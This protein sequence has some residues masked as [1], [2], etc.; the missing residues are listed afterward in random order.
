M[1]SDPHVVER[2][3]I[4]TTLAVSMLTPGI[5]YVF[6]SLVQAE[7]SFV[8]SITQ[9]RILKKQTTVFKAIYYLL[10]CM[11]LYRILGEIIYIKTTTDTVLLYDVM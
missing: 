6:S 3:T 8:R 7:L 4:M 10:L 11:I 1:K 5:L 9:V 2:P